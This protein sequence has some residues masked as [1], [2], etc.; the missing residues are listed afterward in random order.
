MNHFFILIFIFSINLIYSKEYLWPSDNLDAIT[1]TFGEPR[2]ARFHAGIDVRTYGQINEK[3]YAIESGHISRINLSPYKYGKAI[4]L[5]LNDG[6]IVLYSHINS[7][8]KKIENFIDS[9]KIRFNKNYFDYNL[10]NNEKINFNKGELIAYSGDSGSLTGP[11]LH[12]EIRDSLN[13][14]LNPLIFFK[15]FNDTINPIIDELAF[16]PLSN[17]TWINGIQDYVKIKPLKIN[18]NK[19][20]INDTIST[21][22]KFGIAINSY[23][24]VNNQPFKFGIY[25]IELFINNDLYYSIKFDKYSFSEDKLIN[26]E[27]DFSLLQNKERFHRLFLADEF[28]LNFV[29]NNSPYLLVDNKYHNITI[30]ISDISNNKIQLQGVITGQMLTMPNIE[31]FLS[32]D[33]TIII[34]EDNFST[35]IKSRFKEY[36]ENLNI[37]YEEN[38][39]INLS[40]LTYPF[41][42]LEYS[43]KKNGIESKK[44]FF[45]IDK[46]DPYNIDGSIN[47]KHLDSGI[48]IE[49]V[50]KI[51]S[52]YSPQL[53]IEYENKK[54]KLPFYRKNKNI[55][56]SEILN[57]TE[58]DNI[59]KINIIYDS[60]PSKV[61]EKKIIGFY[62]NN[63]SEFLYKNI[64]I[65]ANNNTTMVPTLI[66]IEDDNTNYKFQDFKVIIEPFKIN[67]TS[68]PFEKGL[69]LSTNE[70]CANCSFYKFNG[71]RWKIVSSEIKNDR[72]SANIKYSG[73]YALLEEKNNP[74][75][76]N[77]TPA[78]NSK[79]NIKDLNNILFNVV[80]E[81]SRINPY[82][83]EIYLNNKKM[84]YDYIPYRNLIS[85]K[86]NNE[87]ILG[88]NKIE[89]KISDK[90]G[91]QKN[92]LGEFIVIE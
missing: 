22:G 82:N 69:N 44:E 2:T 92:I 48:I 61:F 56:S 38:N 89:I 87:I 88:E 24:K 10:K 15:E 7:F 83:V 5:T 37:L 16:I 11:H 64:I 91:N 86:I 18:N 76:S 6:N 43:H 35:N 55:F 57:V 54:Y 70:N 66:W 31:N 36:N 20:V 45:S 17:N 29:N 75:I 62:S 33:S 80:D 41:D 53:E 46:I 19:Y 13:N 51:F 78:I 32:E 21:V 8:P 28:K 67:P 72:V 42:V 14:P 73:V 47:I 81:Q 85:S 65:N 23:D 1:A 60:K 49:F 84:F 71:G 25:E 74:I 9:L 59:K 27:L 3:L 40:Q 34:F 52:G 58:L 68:I 4:Y 50:E 77:L 79:Y 63:E 12:F 39:I 30:N 26:Q 90:V